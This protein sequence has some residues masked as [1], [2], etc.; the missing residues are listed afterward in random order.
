MITDKNILVIDR[1]D[2]LRGSAAEVLRRRGFRVVEEGGYQLPAD[3]PPDLVLL[4]CV[5][6]SGAEVEFVHA[7]VSK[8]MPVL[9][10]ASRLD[11]LESRELFRLG[12]VDVV[13]RPHQPDQLED[14]VTETLSELARTGTVEAHAVGTDA[15]PVAV[16]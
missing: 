4:G 9:V 10:T 13:S 3:R 11:L 6:I 5:S 2:H 8:N 1:L 14:L 7:L 12:A 16:G 15:V